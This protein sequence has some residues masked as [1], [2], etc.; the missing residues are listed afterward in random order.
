LNM[1]SH[2]R[3]KSTMKSPILVTAVSMP[4]LW[5]KRS[6]VNP[7]IFSVKVSYTVDIV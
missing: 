5:Q 6:L 7:N 1:A 2:S 3:T 4:P